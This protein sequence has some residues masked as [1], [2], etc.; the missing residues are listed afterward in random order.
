MPRSGDPSRSRVCLLAARQPLHV[1]GST[2]VSSMVAVVV[3]FFFK[4]EEEEE[5]RLV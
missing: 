5:T 3:S 2:S 4:V 1:G